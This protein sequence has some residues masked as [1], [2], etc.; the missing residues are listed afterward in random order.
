MVLMKVILIGA[1]K[2]SAFNF[3]LNGHF[4]NYSDGLLNDKLQKQGF[5]FNSGYEKANLN[6]GI[7]LFGNLVNSGI[8]IN[9]GLPTPETT[10]LAKK[11]TPFRP[12]QLSI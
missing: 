3:S 8:P 11:F 7:S 1:G 12:F 5:S 9:L 4:L 10:L 6:L 2:K